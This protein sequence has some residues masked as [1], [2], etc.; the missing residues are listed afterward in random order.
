[1]GSLSIVWDVEGALK[2]P[3]LKVPGGSSGEESRASLSPGRGNILR[4]GTTLNLK[5]GGPVS[6]AWP[7]DRP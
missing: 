4:K 6:S 7:S 3:T 2:P 5:I 1:M